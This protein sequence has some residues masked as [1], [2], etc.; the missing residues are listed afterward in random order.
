[1]SRPAPDVDAADHGSGAGPAL[2]DAA[3]TGASRLPYGSRGPRS[4]G[5]AFYRKHSF[6]PDRCSKTGLERG[7]SGGCTARQP[8]AGHA[9]QRKALSVKR[10]AS[11]ILLPSCLWSVPRPSSGPCIAVTGVVP[12]A[13]N[14]VGQ[15]TGGAAHDERRGDRGPSM[16]R[17]ARPDRQLGVVQG[18]VSDAGRTLGWSGGGQA[19]AG[20]VL[21]WVPPAA[22]AGFQA[23]PVVTTAWSCRRIAAAITAWA[24]VGASL[25]CSRVVRCR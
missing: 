21:R 23:W 5:Q 17:G 20:A 2:L 22:I 12:A 1:M 24:W 10:Y 3:R 4:C 25:L 11:W 14:R 18:M 16:P 9:H 8:V 13:C 19:A 15:T 7:K 6:V